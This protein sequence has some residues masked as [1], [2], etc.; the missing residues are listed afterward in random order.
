M[1]KKLFWDRTQQKTE[2]PPQL[3]SQ[4]PQVKTPPLFQTIN[5]L[6]PPQVSWKDHTER[7][8]AFL[9]YLFLV[10]NTRWQDAETRCRRFLQSTFPAQDNSRRGEELDRFWLDNEKKCSDEDFSAN[11]KS[12]ELK[13]GQIITTMFTTVQRQSHR[14]TRKQKKKR[15]GNKF[16]LLF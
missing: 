1:N 2:L 12:S 9:N 10:V 7:N 6:V 15:T 11:C 8:P 13:I 4:P 16:W 14:K 3:N 5:D